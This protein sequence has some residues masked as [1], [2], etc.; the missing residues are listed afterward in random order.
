MIEEC[1]KALQEFP[2]CIVEIGAGYGENTIKFL[3]LAEKYDRQ[4]VVIDPFESG[5]EGMPPT[6]RYSSKIFYARVEPLKHR[7]TVHTLNSLSEEAFLL[8]KTKLYDIAFAFIDGLQFMGAVVWDLEMVGNRASVVCVDDMDR[9]T[10]ESQVPQAVKY[11][12][13]RY[14]E[15]KLT[16]K[17]RWAFIR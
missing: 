4:V 3:D 5:W 10:G 9:K 14:T 13:T 1:E 16:I 17:D 2:G 8:C 15:K 12:T 11:F 6:Y 7:L